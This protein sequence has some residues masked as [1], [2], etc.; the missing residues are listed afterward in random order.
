MVIVIGII[1][2]L[3]FILL[4]RYIYVQKEM[5]KLTRELRRIRHEQTNERMQITLGHDPTERLAVEINKLIEEKQEVRGEAI[6]SEQELKE[7]I[8]GM[9][10]DLRTP[11]TAIMGYVQLLDRPTITSEEHAH[12]VSIIHGRTNQLHA[13]IQSFFALSA[14]QSGEGNF[15]FEQI[16][17]TAMV[18]STVLPYYDMF[19][20]QE[21]EVHFSLPGE[22][23]LMI[24]DI[25]A[26]RRIIENIVLNALQHGGASI[27]VRIEATND[28]VSLVVRNTLATNKGLEKEHLF[29]RLYTS[30]PTR[31]AHRGLGLPIVE[32]LMKEMNGHVVARIEGEM[33]TIQCTWKK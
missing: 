22:K 25:I 33:F 15:Q 30:D 20:E 16:D 19:Q 17:L 28:D 9:S 1:I 27:E 24:G 2:V 31:R 5:N 4:F 18:Q 26:C 6:R 13:L 21:K 12:Y 14:M 29:H 23:V 8:A 10:H 11:L 32:R 7:M 3:L